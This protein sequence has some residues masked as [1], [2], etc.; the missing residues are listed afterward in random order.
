MLVYSIDCVPF[1]FHHLYMKKHNQKIN[2]L[3]VALED[4]S[5]TAAFF[6]VFSTAIT[7][8]ASTANK[9]KSMNITI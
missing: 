6:K 7:E 8:N 2:L 3:Y 9:K 5:P 1:F 4:I